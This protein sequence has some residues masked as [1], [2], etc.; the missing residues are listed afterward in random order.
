[1]S[2][3]GANRAAWLRTQYALDHHARALKP[4][5]QALQSALDWSGV[6]HRVGSSRGGGN[7]PYFDLADGRRFY[8]RARR[9]GGPLHLTVRER[10]T[11][12]E[13]KLLSER[14]SIRFVEAL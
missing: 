14:D 4:V 1:M 9:Y 3:N 7:S 13:I 12:T 11:K 2:K 5:A 10:G 8:V 6:M